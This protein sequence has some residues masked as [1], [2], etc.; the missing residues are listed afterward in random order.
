MVHIHV[1][2]IGHRP[3][4]DKRI[5][6]H[7]CLT[8]R[9]F[10]A[11]EVIISGLK[12][13][14]L[15]ESIKKVV[16]RW[17]G[18]FSVKFDAW[19]DT[20]NM[21]KKDGWYIVHLT[22]YGEEFLKGVKEIK[23]EIKKGYK[24]ILVVVGGKKVPLEM[25]ELADYNLSVGFQPHSEVAALAIFLEHVIGPCFDKQFENSKINIPHSRWGKKNKLKVQ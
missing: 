21:Y 10:G 7:V 19:K 18:Q 16:D 20:V 1:L 22:M 25:Y 11:E 3:E 24:G 14:K 6:T 5:T 17:G 13:P 9:M 23:G 8:A 12:D 2:R 4:R 15:T